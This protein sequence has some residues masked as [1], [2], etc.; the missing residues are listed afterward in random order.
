MSDREEFEDWLKVE[1]ETVECKFSPGGRRYASDHIEAMWSAWQAARSTPMAGEEPPKQA[2]A[3][4]YP[5]PQQVEPGWVMVPVEPTGEM[6]AALCHQAAR[7]YLFEGY[8]AMLKA[9]TKEPKP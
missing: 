6:L 1:A 4:L 7:G 8:R 3:Q 5:P 2:K 9:A